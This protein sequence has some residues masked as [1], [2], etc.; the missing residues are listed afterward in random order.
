MG[1]AVRTSSVFFRIGLGMLLWAAYG[2]TTGL[3]DDST[4]SQQASKSMSIET[5]SFG[6][7]KDGQE[8]TLYTCR[9]AKGA[10]LKMIDYG[11]I[12][13]ELHVPDRNGKLANVNVGFDKIDGYL[14]RH[15]YFGATVGRYANRIGGAKF[16]IDGKTYELTANNGKNQLHGGKQGFDAVMWKGEPVKKDDAVGVKFTYRSKD[17][18]EGFPGNLDTTV[19]YLLTNDNELRIDYEA[20]TDKPTHV[21][22]TNHNYWNLAGAN[23][24]SILKHEVMLAADKFVEVDEESIPTGDLPDVKGGVMDFTTSHAIGERIKELKNKPQGYDHAYVLRGEKGKLKLAARV[25]EPTTGRIMEIHTTEPGIQFYTGN[26]LDGSAG[27]NGLK[28]HE[29]FC[30]ETGHFPDSPNQSKFPSTL[31]RPGETYKSTTVHKFSAE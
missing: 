15:P 13:V 23:A 24:G 11:A 17:G 29:A 12:V 26:Y 8:V 19:T 25:K 28:Q 14:E 9:N 6:K 1:Y 20:K 18:E 5:S 4:S 31:L 3:A 16:E 30:L 10:V 22:L 21:N 2:V 27:G 7:T